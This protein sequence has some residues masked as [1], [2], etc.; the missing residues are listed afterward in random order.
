MYRR[1]RVTATRGWTDAC[2]ERRAASGRSRFRWQ[3]PKVIENANVH[4]P[5]GLTESANGSQANRTNEPNHG[6]ASG[7][8]TFARRRRACH[9]LPTLCIASAPPVQAAL[10]LACSLRSRRSAWTGPGS[11]AGDPRDE[12]MAGFVHDAR[13]HPQ[14][15]SLDIDRPS[16]GS[17]WAADRG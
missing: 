8:M 13:G 9:S 10:R 12:G 14:L 4:E 2:R 16:H 7:A 6:R 17:P 15:N 3:R 11:D 5:A 1:V